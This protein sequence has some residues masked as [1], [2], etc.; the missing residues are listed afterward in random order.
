M[1]LVTMVLFYVLCLD[2]IATVLTDLWSFGAG[3]FSA[4]IIDASAKLRCDGNL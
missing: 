2:D 3:D 4:K 1:V